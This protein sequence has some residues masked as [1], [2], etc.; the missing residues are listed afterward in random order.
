MKQNRSWE[1]DSS[2]AGQEIPRIL[3]NPMVQYRRHKLQPTVPILNQIN[4]VD[5]PFMPLLEDPFYYY[6]PIYASVF[7][8]ASFYQVY[9]SKSCM[10]LSCPPHVPHVQPISPFLI[11]L[12]E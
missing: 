11:W 2:G 9:P 7:Q 6:P 8:V 4:P 5:A 1:A 12:P 3:W 10:H